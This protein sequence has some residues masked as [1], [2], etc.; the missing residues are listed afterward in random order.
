M[1]EKAP[2]SVI[3]IT[4]CQSFGQGKEDLLW[5]REKVSPTDM[6]IVTFISDLVFVFTSSGYLLTD[7][8]Y[9]NKSRDIRRL[10]DR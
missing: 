1:K 8:Y 9:H 2:P 4:T 6:F 7:G 3:R 5:D 10:K